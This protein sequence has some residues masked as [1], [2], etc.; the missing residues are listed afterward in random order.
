MELVWKCNNC[1]EEIKILKKIIKNGHALNVYQ[2]SVQCNRCKKWVHKSCTGIPDEKIKDKTFQFICNKCDTHEIS[3]DA[4][5]KKWL[6]EHEYGPIT[7][8]NKL[9]SKD[10]SNASVEDISKLFE[11][12]TK[13]DGKKKTKS[14]RKTKRSKKKTK[15]SKKKKYIK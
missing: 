9:I 1:D 14:K 4:D 3:E 5:I 7:V 6:H 2:P 15:S 8:D 12:V 10:I 13:K 11:T